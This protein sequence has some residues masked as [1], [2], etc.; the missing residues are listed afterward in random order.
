MAETGRAA[1]YVGKRKP[2]EL[3]EYPVPDPKSRDAVLRVSQANVCGSDLHIWRGDTDLEAL[4]IGY[5]I[6]LGH[7]LCGRVH[8]LGSDCRSDALGRTLREGDRVVVTYYVHCESCRVCLRGMPHACL[9]SLATPIRSCEAPPHFTGGFA[10][11]YYAKARQRLLK[12]PDAVPDA[13]AAGV[14]CALSQILYGFERA[15]LELG[16]RVVVQGAGGLGLFA[17][18]VAREHGASKIVAIDGVSARLAAA[19]RFGADEVIDVRELADPRQRVAR[20]MELTDG[21]ADVVV[22]VVGS[23]EVVPEGIRM[24]ARTGRYLEIGNINPR[25]TYKADP[26]LLVGGNLSILGVSLYPPYILDRALDFLLRTQDRY[27]FAELVSHR[28]PLARIDAAF[29]E[30]DVFAR[31]DRPVTR[32]AILPEQLA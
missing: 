10:D 7:E 3:R 19:R 27:P 20:V 31:A 13:V 28:Y 5:G 1:V 25:R 8:K 24:L 14:N 18:A 30:S 26:S 22:E 2:F 9:A 15:R 11:Y 23:P 32:A 21:G 29:E 4:G 17:C 16:E 6:V 12:V